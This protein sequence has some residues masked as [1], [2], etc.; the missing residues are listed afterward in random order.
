M[1]RTEITLIVAVGLIAVISAL[2]WKMAQDAERKEMASDFCEG[3]VVLGDG[4]TMGVRHLFCDDGR[5]I[6]LR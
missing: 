4:G 3:G 5:V 6:H 1:S 2:G